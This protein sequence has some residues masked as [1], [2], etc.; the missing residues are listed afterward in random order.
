MCAHVSSP[1]R[2]ALARRRVKRLRRWTL[3]EFYVRNGVTAP[4]FSMQLSQ[5]SFITE[6]FVLIDWSINHCDTVSMSRPKE[7]LT[8]SAG[9]AVLSTARC[10]D[11]NA[12]LSYLEVAH[13]NRLHCR[14]C[15]ASCFRIDANEQRA[16]HLS[17]SLWPSPP[18]WV[19]PLSA[20][21]DIGAHFH[22]TAI[23]TKQDNYNGTSATPDDTTLPLTTHD[24][25]QNLGMIWFWFLIAK[26]N[27]WP[28]VLTDQ[29]QRHWSIGGLKTIGKRNF[30]QVKTEMSMPLPPNTNAHERQILSDH[31]SILH[32]RR[33]SIVM[34]KF[35]VS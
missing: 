24:E 23:I 20:N 1:F 14:H 35:L 17:S 9:C 6:S 7:A 25:I 34:S 8:R 26:S 28:T 15:L 5:W 11:G 12:C 3:L 33:R 13:L 2:C 10:S 32:D 30:V 21:M 18:E 4:L 31:I 22:F 16:P 29:L 27:N 19:N